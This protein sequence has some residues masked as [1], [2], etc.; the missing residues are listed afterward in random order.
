MFGNLNLDLVKSRQ[1]DLR[2]EAD[3]RRLAAKANRANAKKQSGQTR[4]VFGLRLS[5]AA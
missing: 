5:P 1:N 4:R 2:A 3:S